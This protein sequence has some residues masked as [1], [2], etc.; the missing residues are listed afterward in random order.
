MSVNL[1]IHTVTSVRLASIIR[2]P[3]TED[4]PEFF[5][6]HL[7]CGDGLGDGLGEYHEIVM[8]ADRREQLLTPEERKAE[9][10]LSDGAVPSCQGSGGVSAEPSLQ[11]AGLD[12]L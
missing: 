12:S 11:T 6:R 1:G 8:Y 3:A 10:G 5:S 9:S 7:V 2:F 4:H